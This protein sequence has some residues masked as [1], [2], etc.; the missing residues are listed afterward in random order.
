LR[1][2]ER[3]LHELLAA[4]PAAIYTTDAE[5]KITYYNEAAVKFAGRRPVVGSDEWCVSWKLYWPDGTPLPHDQCPMALAL[6][7]NRPIRGKEA[8]AERPDGTRI[9][10]IPFPTPLYDAEGNLIGAINMLVDVSERRQAETQ[11]RVLM[12]ELNHRVKNNMQMLQ[13][14]LFMASQQTKNSEA[15]AVLGDV[16]KR[17]AAMAAA[18]GVLYGATS[19]KN[20]NAVEFVDAVCQAAQQSFPGTVKIVRQVATAELDNDRAMPLALI[21]NELL[22]NAVK[23]GSSGDATQIRVGLA[24]GNGFALYVEDDGPGFDLQSVRDRSS[25]LKL[26]QLLARQLRGQLE[27]SRQ[28]SRCTIRFE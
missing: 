18:Q 2:S 24:N 6:R 20:F 11:Q 7:E 10:F 27:V 5:G 14:L 4:I 8:I 3:R 25:G 9:P 17:I 1:D 21:L 23:Y 19:A 16:S 26:V 12:R 13:S 15:R 22:T 28:P